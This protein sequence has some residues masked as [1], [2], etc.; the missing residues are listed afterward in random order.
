MTRTEAILQLNDAIN[1]G[2]IEIAHGDADEIL[3]KLLRSL[4][5]DDICDLWYKVEKW[6]A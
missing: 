2:D 4:G 6:Y 1:C 5:Y 3:I